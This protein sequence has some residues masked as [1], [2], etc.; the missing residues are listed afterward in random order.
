MIIGVGLDGRLELLGVVHRVAGDHGGQQRLS[1]LGYLLD[2]VF[3]D[4]RRSP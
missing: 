2:R 1:A 4:R 3:V